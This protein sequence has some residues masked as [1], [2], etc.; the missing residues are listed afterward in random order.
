MSDIF[1][2]N[3]YDDMLLVRKD[4]QGRYT[5]TRMVGNY[6]KYGFM[7]KEGV[8]VIPCIY[9]DAGNFEEGIVEVK[10]NGMWGII[11]KAGRERLPFIYEDIDDISLDGT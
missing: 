6:G 5:S 1:K 7:D 2:S 10:K 11:D 3:F 8:E 4:A 9:D